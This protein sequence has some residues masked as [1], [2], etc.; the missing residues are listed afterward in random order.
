[1]ATIRELQARFTASANSLRSTVQSATRDLKGLQ[2]T[3]NKTNK[4][5]ADGSSATTKILG[6]LDD[7]ISKL[8]ETHKKQV[9]RV[10]EASKSYKEM[11][12]E[13]GRNSE[14]AKKAKEHLDKQVKGYNALQNKLNETR[15][16]YARIKIAQEQQ[17]SMFT[18]AGNVIQDASG[19]L[20]TFGDGLQKAGSK[21]TNTFTKPALVATTAVGGLVGALGFKRL[22]GLDTAKGQLLAFTKN[23]ED[24][25]RIMKQVKEASQTGM[26]TLAENT[27]IATSAL[28]AGVK[29]GKDLH[30]YIKLVGDAAVVA[31]VPVDEM[32]QIFSRIQGLGKLTGMELQMIE[33]RMP[34]FT[35]LMAETF[36]VTTDALYDMVSEGA[37]TADMFQEVM[38]SRVKGAADIMA[39]TWQGTFQ[40]MFAYISIIGE[41]LLQDVFEE[42]KDELQSFVKF[43]S[44]PTVL[45]K[46]QELG[47]TIG[48]GFSEVIRR[49]KEVIK[50]FT[51]LDSD[52]QKL[53]GKIGL[54]FI[55]LGPILTI[56]G[57]LAGAIASIGTATGI[58]M[59]GFGMLSG[60]AKAVMGLLGKGGMLRTVLSLGKGFLGLTNPIGLVV[61]I[62][63]TLASAFTIAWKKSDTFR[64]LVLQAFDDL[65]KTLK[66]D[67]ETWKESFE[68]VKEVVG[69]FVDFYV[70]SFNKVAD[71]WSNTKVGKWFKDFKKEHIDGQKAVDVFRSG[72]S[73]ATQDII[74]KYVELSEKTTEQLTQL[75]W[76]EDKQHRDRMKETIDKYKTQGE[77]VPKQLEENYKK[78]M[79][80]LVGHYDALSKTYDEMHQEALTQL[81]GHHK[82]RLK[83]IENHLEDTW[84]IT[85]EDKEK[86]KESEK[87]QYEEERQRLNENNERVQEI[88]KRA[89]EEN[90]DLTR[91]EQERIEELQKEHNTRVI[92]E[93]TE[94]EQEQ[95]IILSRMNNNKKA[96][97]R[98]YVE[99]IIGDS[100]EARKKVV[101]E[102]EQ[103]R[104]ETIAWA[105][106]EYENNENFSAEMRDALIGDAEETYNRTVEQAENRHKDII[107][108]AAQQ[109]EEHGIIV[110]EETGDIL[111]SWD[112]FWLKLHE[113]NGEN[114]ES[115]KEYS[116]EHFSG[117][118]EDWDTLWES[119][120]TTFREKWS[121]FKEYSSEHFGQLREDWNTLWSTL[122]TSFNE[123]WQGFKSYS[124]EHFSQLKQDWNTLKTEVSNRASEMTANAVGSLSSMYLRGSKKVT[125]LKDSGV[126][127]FTEMKDKTLKKMSE[128]YEGTKKWFADLYDTSRQKITES[129]NKVVDTAGDMKTGAIEK[130]NGLV[131]G[132]RDMMDGVKG[133]IDTKKSAV[134]SSATSLGTDIANAAIGGFNKMIGGINKVASL[135]GVDN[136]VSPIPTIGGIKGAASVRM[137]HGGT[138]HHPGGPAIVGDKGIGNSP[139]RQQDIQRHS[140][141]VQLPNGKQFMVHDET[142]IPNLPRGSKVINGK[143]TNEMYGSGAGF[144]DLIKKGINFTKNLVTSPIKTIKNTASSIKNAI[145]D[146]FDYMKNPRKLVDKFIG[147]FD[148]GWELPKEALAIAQGSAFKMK[149]GLTNLFKDWFSKSSI[150]DGSH[151]LNKKINQ[152]FGRYSGNL[153]FNG[154]NH[155]GIDTNHV[156]DPLFSPVNGKVTR[157]WNDFG[158]G[159]SLEVKS[160]D[161]YWWFMHLSKAIKSIGDQ[162]KIGDRL[163]TTGNS[164]AWTTGAHLHTQAM[165]GA[166]GNQNAVDPVPLLKKGMKGYYKGGITDGIPELAFLN[167]E[168]FKESIISWNPARKDR[169]EQIWNT[170]GQALGFVDQNELLKEVKRGNEIA[171]AMLNAIQKD[172]NGNSYLDLD[173]LGRLIEPYVSKEQDYQKRVKG[174]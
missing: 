33:Q 47:K 107:E 75:R 125:D 71:F 77:K 156:F 127:K 124:S 66:E 53:I 4:A 38:T 35:S 130:F 11:T 172:D 74:G 154:G 92:R 100:E 120:F 119:I 49:T 139:Y 14:E 6:N 42:A 1:M 123:G 21:M 28:A 162:V 50:W 168:G 131:D 19:R 78:E 72:V 55:A 9:T 97:N 112:A 10:N 110:D 138:D 26:A 82:D 69:K 129:K 60:G 171:Q 91:V 163:G 145:G 16:D 13:Y 96:L 67:F 86:L 5:M 144:G 99:Q 84:S 73:E 150:A 17:N 173:R 141:V 135:I 44:S 23:A 169:S 105:L 85:D 54:A 51:S 158:G 101:G 41:N 164:G 81:E 132:A 63:A 143:D 109:A 7:K 155:Y 39:D 88:I 106:D 142:L 174:A 76:D 87:E 137:Y 27:N 108:E 45:E 20:R 48:R 2:S 15:K 65:T 111:N 126:E 121:G 68:T 159:L 153:K 122:G 147:D 40:N 25:E 157:R 118:K 93:V 90:R 117:V 114:W 165:P 166:P 128:M 80:K 43:I 58:A 133:W 56:A 32:N 22:V 79:E 140:E 149:D 36:G 57:K 83:E 31:N 151:I 89:K 104:D 59:K 29:E 98:E 148:F 8:S 70:D 52:T 170:T 95:E 64:T 115:F 116:A 18:K 61:T 3:S 152:G 34:G 103:K 167:E 134:V 161:I 24:S 62:L 12:K 102:A 94:G 113:K 46:S 37:V 136:L 146:V 30:N 160:G